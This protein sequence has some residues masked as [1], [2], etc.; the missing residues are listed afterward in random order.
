VNVVCEVVN[1]SSG[2]SQVVFNNGTGIVGQN[3][4]NIDF[5]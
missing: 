4:T 2:T 3:E 5:R 1:L